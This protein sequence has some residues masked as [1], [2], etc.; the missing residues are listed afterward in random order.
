M[1]ANI[2]LAGVD[3]RPAIAF[4]T[5]TIADRILDTQGDEVEALQRAFDRGDINAQRLRRQEPAR[6][7]DAQCQLVDVVFLAVAT[8]GDAAEDARGDARMQVMA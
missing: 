1:D 8:C 3:A 2:R 4:L 7:V 5:E 6:P